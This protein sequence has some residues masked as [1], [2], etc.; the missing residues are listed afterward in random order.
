MIGSYKSVN[1]DKSDR[2]AFSEMFMLGFGQ[3]FYSRHLGRGNRKFL[4]L[5]SGYSVGDVYCTGTDSKLNTVYLA[6]S[7]GLELFK[8]KYFLVDTKVNYFIPITANNRNM[9]GLSYNLS[10]NFVF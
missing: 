7:I 8:N 1:E 10:L 9:R 6:P 5:Y 3:D 4:N 2:N